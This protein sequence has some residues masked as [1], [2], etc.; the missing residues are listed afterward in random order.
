M[1]SL[2]YPNSNTFANQAAQMQ[3][4]FGYPPVD[5]VNLGGLG[6]GQDFQPQPGN[7][8]PG[9]SPGF[10]QTQ[11]PALIPVIPVSPVNQ[12]TPS[13]IPQNTSV[14]NSIPNPN[15]TSASQP[16]S[17][18]MPTA[19]S[20][21]GTTPNANPATSASKA[22]PKIQFLCVCGKKLS[23]PSALSG[24]TIKCPACQTALIVP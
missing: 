24:K 3:P 10:S 21:M 9:N 19:N 18:A 15:P 16:T 17:D 13:P 12:P 23:G 1:N 6:A 22:D 4:E 2:E 11:N 14:P 8:I 7:P 20:Q 5:G